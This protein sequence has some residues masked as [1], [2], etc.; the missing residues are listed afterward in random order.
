MLTRRAK[1]LLVTASISGLAYLNHQLP[2]EADIMDPHPAVEVYEDG[3]G[4][5]Y[6]PDGREI[7]T[8]PEGTF[9]WDCTTMG[10]QICGPLATYPE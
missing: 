6:T 2:T 8:F 10:N 3:S 9:A 4:V 1:I 7:R 5:Q